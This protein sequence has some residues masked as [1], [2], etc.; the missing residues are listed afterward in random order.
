MLSRFIKYTE[1]EMKSEATA[2]F[3]DLN[4]ASTWAMDEIDDL[5]RLGIINGK[6]DNKFDPFAETTRGEISTMLYR[7]IRIVINNSIK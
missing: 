7:L 5:Q 2:T 3:D 1:I 6:S 4:L